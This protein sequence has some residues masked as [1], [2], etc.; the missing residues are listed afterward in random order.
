MK[1]PILFPDNVASLK[2]IILAK[3]KSTWASD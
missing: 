3:N 2:Q 1:Y